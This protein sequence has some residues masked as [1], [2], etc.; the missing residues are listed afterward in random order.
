LIEQDIQSKLIRKLESDGYYVIKLIKTNKN[1]I[2]D[3][4]AIPKGG[5]AIF[6]E[7]KKPGKNPTPLQQF[8]I[9][10]LKK[11]GIKA[12]TYTGSEGQH[13]ASQVDSGKK[14]RPANN[15]K[16]QKKGDRAGKDDLLSDIKPKRGL[17][18]GD[19]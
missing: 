4:L 18:Q 12:I 5:D 3:V 1:G 19:S 14:N 7:V 2:P 6:I 8:R 9:K 16:V 17:R 13:S 10:E 11:H 15:D